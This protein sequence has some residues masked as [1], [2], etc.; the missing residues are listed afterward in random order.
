MGFIF[1]WGKPNMFSQG[2]GWL[3][4]DNMGCS[5]WWYSMWCFLK[6]QQYSPGEAGWSLREQGGCS[7]GWLLIHGSQHPSPRL[8]GLGQGF[9]VT[10]FFWRCSKEVSPCSVNVTSNILLS[11][12]LHFDVER[13]AS[14]QLH[15]I[16]LVSKE[17]FK[18]APA[19]GQEY[20]S[21]KLET[22]T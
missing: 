5:Y 8:S 16:P 22:I 10:L 6:N 20:T 21:L 14:H 3:L 18:R 11:E 1:L 15:L 19:G 12:A 17:N 7:G 13:I 2:A 4:M 9:N